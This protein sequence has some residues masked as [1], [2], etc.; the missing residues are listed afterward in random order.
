MFLIN[1]MKVNYVYSMMY[2]FSIRSH[3]YTNIIECIFTP[4]TVRVPTFGFVRLFL[5]MTKKTSLQRSL[6]TSAD[7][8]QKICAYLS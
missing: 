5:H 1:V 2:F 3:N 4:N 6:P 8:L 7:L